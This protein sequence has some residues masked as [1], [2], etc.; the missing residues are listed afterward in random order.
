MY[1][2]LGR[3]PLNL[4]DEGPQRRRTVSTSSQ[5]WSECRKGLFEKS[6]GMNFRMGVEERDEL[7]EV[8][9]LMEDYIL[10]NE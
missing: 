6:G 3:S 5:E 8:S 1:E 7:K 9:G 2:T 10:H 4:N